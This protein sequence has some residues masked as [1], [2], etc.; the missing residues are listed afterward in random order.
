MDP[1]KVLNE[2]ERK[3]YS[4][5]RIRLDPDFSGNNNGSGSDGPVSETEQSTSQSSPESFVQM[6]Q[7]LPAPP[8]LISSYPSVMEISDNNPILKH[9][10]RTPSPMS[11]KSVTPVRIMP[12]PKHRSSPNFV[13]STPAVSAAVVTKSGVQR[14]N[15]VVSGS[16]PERGM[17][18]LASLVESAQTT[19]VQE[20]YKE[21]TYDPR[22]A[23]LLV[24]G[25]LDTSTWCG[26]HS[27]AFLNIMETV[28][29]FMHLAALKSPQFKEVCSHDQRLLLKNNAILLR[30]Y[31]M[32]RYLIAETGMEQ[33]V[34]AFGPS[35]SIKLG[36]S[37][38]SQ[39]GFLRLQ[40]FLDA[41]WY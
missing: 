39:S 2:E 9:T 5:K 36:K 26:S 13:N 8:P 33:L 21:F 11:S 29:P 38:S 37:I 20:V 16:N 31:M 1:S 7:D 41:F 24:Q 34:W 4:Q 27:G 18:D 15:S 19:F 30:E 10:F 22:L 14:A 28:V 25:H 3:K 6:D 12:K 35:D 23:N 17:I 40:C 32:A